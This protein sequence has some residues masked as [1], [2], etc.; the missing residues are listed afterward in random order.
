VKDYALLKWVGA[1]SYRTSHY[2]Y[3]DE[4]MYLADRE[5]ILIIDEIPAVGLRFDDGQGNVKARAAQCRQQIRELVARD[6]NHPSVIAWSIAN[7]PFPA[8]LVRRFAG[9]GTEE[10]DTDAIGTQFFAEM[11]GLT[12][13][14]DP[15]RPVTL[16][17]VMG[18]PIA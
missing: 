15:T 1:N 8:S 6:K 2:P 17:G 18:G 5:G 12:R 3:A 11:F 14:L 16:V 13:D 4:A 9:G 7:E 10:E